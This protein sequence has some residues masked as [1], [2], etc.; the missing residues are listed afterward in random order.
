MPDAM[1][2]RVSE[3]RKSGVA[4]IIVLG[5][6]AILMML[7]MS[8][9]IQ[10]RIERILADYT[11]G[12]FHVRDI[13]R[14]A[15]ADGMNA[16]SRDLWAQNLVYPVDEYFL[17][18]DTGGDSGVALGS[19]YRLLNGGALDWVPGAYLPTNNSNIDVTK[20]AKWIYV[21]A[22]DPENRNNE[23]VV[24]RYAYVC[25]DMSGG[26][27]ANLLGVI[28]AHQDPP[29]RDRNNIRNFSQIAFQNLS[30]ISNAVSFF[31]AQEDMNGFDSLYELVNNGEG[32]HPKR[33]NNLTPYSMSAY[34]GVYDFA[35]GSWRSNGIPA[36]QMTTAAHWTSI[37]PSSMR[38]HPNTLQD[39]LSEA[40]T[41]LGVDYP[42]SKNIPM[43][44][45]VYFKVEFEES[46]EP[47]AGGG[48]QPAYH[49]NV[50]F[51]PEFWF[52]FPSDD[53]QRSE[54]FTFEAP[55][56]AGGANA[57]GSADIWFRAGLMGSSSVT[58]QVVGTVTNLSV[59][60]KYN[61][62]KPYTNG[63]IQCQLK[64]IKSGT[65]A[66][67]ANAQCV[68]LAMNFAGQL[69]LKL[70]NTVVDRAGMGSKRL[71]SSPRL[72][73]GGS[74][75]VA[76]EVSDPRL[77]HDSSA[78]DP[79]FK[80]THTLHAM[81]ERTESQARQGNT[82]H[83]FVTGQDEEIGYAMYCRNGPMESPA[84]LGHL[85][86][87][88]AWNTVDMCTVE[89]VK[90]MREVAP[91]MDT[92]VFIRNGGI[93]Y[94]NGTVNP[95]TM[96]EEV[97]EVVFTDFTVGIS[98]ATATVDSDGAKRIASRM[99]DVSRS[100]TF[101]DNITLSRAT[102]LSPG[103]W[104]LALGNPALQEELNLYKHQREALIHQTWGLF[105][106]ED[107]LFTI[108]LIGQAIKQGP[109]GSKTTFNASE[110]QIVGERRAVALVWRDPFPVGSSSRHH[111]MSVLMFKTLAE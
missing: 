29:L 70:G 83:S 1:Q 89:M 104:A 81:N 111:E 4:L 52:P 78:W 106:P 11:L 5:F 61:A 62:G 105:R 97:L 6:L 79:E 77:N 90:V 24:G 15:L 47:A 46:T 99:T 85:S 54:R 57:S 71:S 110:D 68:I 31:R 100:K 13:V 9:L 32:L 36:E 67:P 14:T 19:E 84:E 49:L 75:E 44:N 45:E 103:D 66:L 107:S 86:I 55:S 16:Y 72:S 58:W 56:M 92:N 95:N 27:D 8:F 88:S 26:L 94:T 82:G 37:I 59:E 39:Y 101:E 87:G 23:I 43:I 18:G 12:N 20:D 3:C 60:A 38:V 64:A 108:L 17:S 93:F 65:N 50:T 41:P 7:G 63:V 91:P 48:T 42:S 21:K 98:N 102:F 25:F 80:T 96:R 28:G 51:I 69:D 22:P 73:H 35:G 2:C 33:L 34:R 10:A 53:N 76:L 40:D 74:F 30:D 109:T